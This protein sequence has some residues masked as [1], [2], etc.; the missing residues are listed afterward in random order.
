MR[1]SSS[2]S[3]GSRVS[4]SPAFDCGAA[5][6]GGPRRTHHHSFFSTSD[7]SAAC[8]RPRIPETARDNASSAAAPRLPDSLRPSVRWNICRSYLG[9]GG[10]CVRCPGPD[11]MCS[12][13][14][15]CLCTFHDQHP[16]GTSVTSLCESP[17]C[18]ASCPHLAASA[19]RLSAFRVAPKVVHAANEDKTRWQE[20]HGDTTDCMVKPMV[21]RKKRRYETRTKKKKS[22]HL[23]T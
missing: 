12:S 22:Q 13:P 3:Q 1:A 2:Q 6:G 19:I 10:G 18:L 7:D 11:C 14:G 16:H 8:P 5:A 4:K 20:R 15:A 17:E 23:L 9:P 21:L